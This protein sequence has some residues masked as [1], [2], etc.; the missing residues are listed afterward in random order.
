[1]VAEPLYPTFVHPARV[2]F[3][4]PGGISWVMLS[5]FPGSGGEFKWEVD[6]ALIP[7]HLRPLGSRFKVRHEY[8]RESGHRFTIFEDV[9]PSARL[10]E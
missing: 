2:E 10:P 6:T 1:M 5:E 4:A 9:V 7:A 3:H 8:S